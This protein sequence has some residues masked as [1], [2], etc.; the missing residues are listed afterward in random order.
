MQNQKM[1][2]RRKY[3]IAIVLLAFG[4]GANGQEPPKAVLVDEFGNLPCDD[5]MARLDH[6]YSELHENPSSSGFV[7]IANSPDKRRDS[8]FRQRMIENYTRFRGFDLNRIKIVRET[9][10]EEM[11]VSFWRLPFGSP[12]P[13]VDVDGTYEIPSTIKKPFMFGAEESHGQME[14]AEYSEEIFARFLNA[15]PA[16]RA[17]L[18]F[19]DTTSK[20]GMRRANRVVSELVEK[21][22]IVRNRIRVFILRPSTHRGGEPITEFWYLP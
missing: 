8:V 6:L 14:C 7:V 21:H 20:A 19:R 18:V 2:R 11:K 4:I 16:A 12:E 13:K 1:T 15:N 10:G 17:N 9:V 3:L 22:G 5:S